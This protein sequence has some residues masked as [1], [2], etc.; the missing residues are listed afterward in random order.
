MPE[1]KRA[2]RQNEVVDFKAA[3]DHFF[4]GDG[5]VAAAAVN[6]EEFAGYVLQRFGSIDYRLTMRAG[7][8][9]VEV[10]IE[11]GSPPAPAS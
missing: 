4:P 11:P 10:N 5:A 9:A 3:A 6:E 2:L 8:L 7:T 1:P